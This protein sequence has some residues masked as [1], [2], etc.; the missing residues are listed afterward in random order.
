MRNEKSMIR[1]TL[2]TM[3]HIFVTFEQHSR[4]AN[5]LRAA[6]GMLCITHRGR[7][8]WKE[9]LICQYPQRLG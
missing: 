8:P 2:D 3:P 7:N 9:E 5:P 4:Y 1:K 6:D